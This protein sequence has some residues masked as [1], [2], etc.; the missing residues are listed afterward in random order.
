MIDWDELRKRFIAYREGDAAAAREVFGTLRGQALRPFFRAR[1][2]SPEEA[3]DLTQATLLKLHFARD[4]FAAGLALKTWVFTIAR[5]SLIDHWR[6]ARPETVD[7][8]EVAETTADSTLGP[9]AR[10][11]LRDGLDRALGPLKPD[12]RSIVYLYAVE[13]FTMAEIAET[14]GLTE[15]AVKVRAHRA[16]VRARKE[17]V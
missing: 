4:R 1:L 2:V 10:A 12:D 7:L 15:A 9:E 17:L 6:G 8:D 16:Y 3:E 13:G 14:M 5:R 11:E